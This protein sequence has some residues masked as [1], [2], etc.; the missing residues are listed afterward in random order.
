MK[1]NKLLVCGIATVLS[2]GAV[3]TSLALYI[4][5]PTDI[6]IGIGGSI[7]ND[8]N[9]TIG[10]KI[11]VS[12]KEGNQ[13]I[14]PENAI[15][16]K[17]PIKFTKGTN[18]TYTQDTAVAH[19]EYS[20]YVNGRTDYSGL[21]VTSKVTGY[22]ANSWASKDAGTNNT[23]ELKAETNKIQGVLNAPVHVDQNGNFIEF[24]FSYTGEATSFATHWLAEKQLTLDINVSFPTAEQYTM[25]YIVGTKTGWAEYDKYMMV[26]DVTTSEYSW[27]YDGY[28]AEVGEQF[29]AILAEN[30]SAGGNYN[31]DKQELAGIKNVTWTGDS[32]DGVV[33]S[34]PA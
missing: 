10:D 16:Y 33:V 19:I 15:T 25:A 8:G 3:A 4:N 32:K 26:P 31:V 11:I 22:D 34:N 1:K 12:T 5:K 30:W 20:V 7:V 17:Y 18:S 28:V 23:P 29:K 2:I 9:Y 24:T 13:N 14:N 21:A 27:K 6:K